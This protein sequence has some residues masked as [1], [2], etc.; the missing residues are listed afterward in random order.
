MIFH[1]WFGLTQHLRALATVPGDLGLIPNTHKWVHKQ[2]SLQF[3]ESNAVFWLP[4]VPD[5]QW[6]CRQNIRTHRIKPNPKEQGLANQGQ[7][8]KSSS[9]DLTAHMLKIKFF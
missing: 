3:Q 6:Y 9:P 5:T 7:Q 4:S 2:L 8:P 1:S